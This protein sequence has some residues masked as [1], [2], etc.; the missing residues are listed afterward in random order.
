MAYNTTT[1]APRGSEF[2]CSTATATAIRTQSRVESVKIN[3]EACTVSIVSTSQLLSSARD[4]RRRAVIEY[5]T[6]DK[7]IGL[8][9]A[10]VSVEH[11]CKAY[12][13]SLHGTLIL[14]S[15]PGSF[16]SLLH[17]HGF[18]HLA[19]VQSSPK[20]IG[21][22]E[23]WQRVQRMVD[24]TTID[25]ARLRQL[26]EIRNGNLHLGAVPLGALD[27]IFLEFIQV[28]ERLE[29]VIDPAVSDDL[30]WGDFWGARIEKLLANADEKLQQEVERLIARADKNVRMK[31]GAIPASATAGRRAVLQAENAALLTQ[32]SSRHDEWGYFPLG[33]NTHSEPTRCP[34]PACMDENALALGWI[35]EPDEEEQ[36]RRFFVY[37]FRC[38]V[39][40]LHLP[41]ILYVRVVS[42]IPPYWEIPPN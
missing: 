23:A 33:N 39:C 12:L 36:K 15:G 10:G 18:A 6:A 27:R 7:S 34:V 4:W 2:R 14:E 29:R 5:F 11:L 26:I 24:M 19:K 31:L 30:L 35:A 3:L 42:G 22:I 28:T 40:E 8:A 13:S 21:A 41:T 32:P 17:F 1:R 16:N 20:T 9:L 38:G 25:D 37:Q